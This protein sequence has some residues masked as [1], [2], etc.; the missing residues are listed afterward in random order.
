MSYN[1]EV[2]CDVAA[3]TLLHSAKGSRTR[4]AIDLAGFKIQD[5]GSEKY[6]KRVERKRDRLIIEFHLSPLVQVSL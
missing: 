3:V 5:A 2:L 6:R 4:K 1:A